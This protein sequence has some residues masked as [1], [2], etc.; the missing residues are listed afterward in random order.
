M[1]PCRSF[2][3]AYYVQVLNATRCLLIY[4]PTFVSSVLRPAGYISSGGDRGIEDA[5]VGLFEQRKMHALT[6]SNTEAL[7]I[8]Q[9]TTRMETALPSR[10]QENTNA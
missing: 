10:P 4:A 8:H 1:R 5:N 3:G 6:L 2:A 9:T 7:L